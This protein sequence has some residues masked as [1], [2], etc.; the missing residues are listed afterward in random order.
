[1]RPIRPFARVA[2][3][4]AVSLGVFGAG[5]AA[6][7]DGWDLFT[8]IPGQTAVTLP[9]PF[10]GLG[11]IPMRGN[12]DR[13]VN[14]FKV[15]EGTNVDTI[16]RRLVGGAPG[17]TVPIEL[18][19]LSLRSVGPVNV[20]LPPAS[21]QFFDV[22]IDV[23]G[24]SAFRCP[25]LATPEDPAPRCPGGEDISEI[26][27]SSD[28]TGG[29]TFDSLLTITGEVRFISAADGMTVIGDPQIFQDD[30]DTF[31][32][33]AS[34]QG[35]LRDPRNNPQVAAAFPAAG[36]YPG[37]DANNNHK[38]VPVQEDG[39]TQTTHVVIPANTTG[40]SVL[41]CFYECKDTAQQGDTLLQET[42]TLMIVNQNPEDS[43]TPVPHLAHVVFFDGNENALGRSEVFLSGADLD[44]VNVCSTLDNTAPYTGPA[45]GLVKIAV[46]DLRAQSDLPVPDPA[47]IGE[48]VVAW[49]KNVL[50]RQNVTSPEPFQS[51]NVVAGVG[52]TRCKAASPDVADAGFVLDALG[53]FGPV[54]NETLIE[55]TGT[56]EVDP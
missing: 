27:I 18:V 12:P 56:G 1:M 53:S 13:V 42:T 37:V 8:T 14:N 35:S 49:V 54:L 10:E 28:G 11:S 38:K 2:T 34:P 21:G 15:L 36:F 6:A 22:F 29:F 30:F 31:G 39:L 9:P 5:Q 16:V 3:L 33:L 25:T 55:D 4:V 51:P 7:Q 20:E 23:K 43:A 26:S 32:A 45:A 48:G 40:A 47:R 50:G 19:A 17:E 24:G 41:T 46:Q 44:E 52:K